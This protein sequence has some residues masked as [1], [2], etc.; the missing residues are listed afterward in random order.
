[1]VDS[2][3]YT[4]RP[5]NKQSP[6]LTWPPTHSPLYTIFSSSVYLNSRMS[7]RTVEQPG[8]GESQVSLTTFLK[9][10]IQQRVWWGETGRRIHLRVICCQRSVASLR[11]ERWTSFHSCKSTE[12]FVNSFINMNRPQYVNLYLLYIYSNFKFSFINII[13]TLY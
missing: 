3:L 6:L 10:F 5:G 7:L 11:V 13:I 1:M 4:E 9:T 2:V 8:V 12:H